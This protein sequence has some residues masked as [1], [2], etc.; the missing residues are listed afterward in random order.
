MA[1][2]KKLS[3]WQDISRQQKK[4]GL[5]IN[6]FCKKNKIGYSTFYAWRRKLS[7]RF[8]SGFVEV[9]DNQPADK[10][11]PVNE[12]ALKPIDLGCGDI[13]IRVNADLGPS[14]LSQVIKA[15]YYAAEEI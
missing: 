14:K 4:S 10:A 3:Y 12:A 11:Q 6:A 5:S 13:N 15:L 1:D 7:Q 8:E 9:K 2:T